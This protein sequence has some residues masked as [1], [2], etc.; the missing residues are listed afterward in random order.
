MSLK[1]L[2]YTNFKSTI[3]GTQ[4]PVIIDFYAD[5]CGPCKMI[6]PILEQI[7][8]ENDTIELYKVNIDDYPNLAEEFSIMTIPNLI[9]FK[10]G[11]E[12]KRIIGAQPKDA[13]LDLVK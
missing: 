9:C 11:K 5:W 6:A 13:I 8:T 4:K 7:S 2:D 3:E 1:N 12:H 10:D